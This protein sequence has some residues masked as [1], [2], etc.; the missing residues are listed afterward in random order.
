MKTQTGVEEEGDIPLIIK[1]RNLE[2]NK[3]SFA[4]NI[5][6]LDKQPEKQGPGL[7]MYRNEWR[8]GFGE[9]AGYALWACDGFSG[10]THWKQPRAKG[11]TKGVWSHSER[12]AGWHQW[13]SKAWG[14]PSEVKH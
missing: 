8:P 9:H 14:D 13:E 7:G 3:K 1:E 10:D 6:R 5:L 11:D 4:K 12:L 2:V